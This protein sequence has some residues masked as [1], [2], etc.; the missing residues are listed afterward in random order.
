MRS[1]YYTSIVL[2]PI[3][4][5]TCT[6][7]QSPIIINNMLKDYDNSDPPIARD[8]LKFLLTTGKSF[9]TRGW[10]SELGRQ[11]AEIAERV[12]G[13]PQSTRAVINHLNLVL[14]GKSNCTLQLFLWV[15]WI[16]GFEVKLVRRKEIKQKTSIDQ[17]A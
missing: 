6:I 3:G 11:Y 12:N 13:E 4:L 2:F 9:D 15:A 16:L 7:M 17:V 5:F 14:R 8:Y 1:I 10:K